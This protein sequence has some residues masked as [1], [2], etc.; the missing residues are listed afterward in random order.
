M[1]SV[2]E[3]FYM[4]VDGGLKETAADLFHHLIIHQQITKVITY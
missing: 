3:V 2:L 1:F 4:D